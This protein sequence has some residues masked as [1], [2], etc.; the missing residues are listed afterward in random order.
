MGLALPRALEP[1]NIRAATLL[2]EFVCARVPVCLAGISDHAG[3]A[4]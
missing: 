1:V 2:P 4:V 3:E